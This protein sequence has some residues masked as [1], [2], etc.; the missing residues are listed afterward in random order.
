MYRNVNDWI[1]Q[2]VMIKHGEAQEIKALE[3]ALRLRDRPLPRIRQIRFPLSDWDT[4]NSDGG[5]YGAVLLDFKMSEP[6]LIEEVFSRGQKSTHTLCDT[7]LKIERSV[8]MT[9]LFGD[10][11]EGLPAS[12]CID[13]VRRLADHVAKDRA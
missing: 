4:F 8:R 7:S 11:G 5:T 6:H 12:L 13:C 9:H 10:D 1:R 3:A 2:S